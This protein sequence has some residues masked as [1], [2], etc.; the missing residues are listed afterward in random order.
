MPGKP[1]DVRAATPILTV[2][3][4]IVGIVSIFCIYAGIKS[5]GA[6]SHTV[7]E[8]FKVKLTTGDVGVALIGIGVFAMMFVF[9]RLFR[10]I[11]Y[12]AALPDQSSQIKKKSDHH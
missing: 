8:I 9:F 2:V 10:V 6:E 12:L 7:L 11:K 5:V 3:V 4:L 1:A